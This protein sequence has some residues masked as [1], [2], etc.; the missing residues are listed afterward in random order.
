MKCS[1]CGNATLMTCRDNSD[2]LFNCCKQC[3]EASREVKIDKEGKEYYRGQL[4]LSC[5]YKPSGERSKFNESYKANL[6][7]LDYVGSV[8]MRRVEHRMAKLLGGQEV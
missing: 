8:D 2:Q 6:T 4:W 3:Y 1:F 5:I 7:A